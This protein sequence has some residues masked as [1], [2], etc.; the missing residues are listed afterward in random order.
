[1]TLPLNGDGVL[2]KVAS[3]LNNAGLT[4]KGSAGAAL[5]EHLGARPTAVDLL[6]EAT[7]S[8]AWKV[9]YQS[10]LDLGVSKDEAAAFADEHHGRVAE[11]LEER[12]RAQP[13]IDP[14]QGH[15]SGLKPRPHDAL[16]ESVMTTIGR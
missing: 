11:A 5:S 2:H 9:A 16:L 8:Q 12:E 10:A 15:G 1:M 7:R 14:S 13:A 6:T 4:P 3:A